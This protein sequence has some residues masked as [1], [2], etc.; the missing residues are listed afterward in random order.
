MGAGI[1]IAASADLAGVAGSTKAQSALL[2]SLVGVGLAV[3]VVTYGIIDRAHAR[4]EAVSDEL[5]DQTRELQSAREAAQVNRRLLETSSM[6]TILAYARRRLED[7]VQLAL[8]DA[9]VEHGRG[10]R[11]RF[12]V[13]FENVATAE[14]WV[15]PF[16]ADLGQEDVLDWEPRTLGDVEPSQRSDG[17]AKL[18]HTKRLDGFEAR[19]LRLHLRMVCDS[20]PPENRTFRV[21]ATAVAEA[22]WNPS[23]RREVAEFLAQETSAIRGAALASGLSASSGQ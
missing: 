9:F 2:F 3:A 15:P 23:V 5:R 22:A 19:P 1:V 13:A 17:R 18:D 4:L 20:P 10:L 14:W 12:A 21:V 7:T 11:W 16:S 6:D 8:R